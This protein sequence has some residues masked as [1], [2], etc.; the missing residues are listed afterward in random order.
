MLKAIQ[1]CKATWNISILIILKVIHFFQ[2]ILGTIEKTAT[3]F[4][5]ETNR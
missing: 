3:F 2:N 4:L 5:L 1:F